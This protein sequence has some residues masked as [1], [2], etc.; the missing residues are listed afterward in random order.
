MEV[1]AEYLSGKPVQHAKVRVV[2]GDEWEW[3]YHD[4]KWEGEETAPVEGQFDGSGKFIAHVSLKKDFENFTP[5]QWRRSE[6]FDLAAFVTDLSTGRT[7][8]RRFQLGLSA[9][10]IHLYVLNS[11]TG[12]ADAPLLL[13]VTSSYADGTPASMAGSIVGF[14]PKAEGDCDEQPGTPKRVTLSSFHTNHFGV[15]RVELRPLSP[16]LLA[17][18]NWARI[19]HNPDYENQK[20]GYLLLEARDGK[21]QPRCRC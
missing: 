10:P 8:Q 13:Y 3:N 21:G 19:Y 17:S 4:Q 5:N 6:D 15:G 11:G 20:S 12:S 16:D 9:L 14:V 2:R 1:R 18:S 7:E